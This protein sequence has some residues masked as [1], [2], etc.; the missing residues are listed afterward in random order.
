MWHLRACKNSVSLSFL[1]WIKNEMIFDRISEL[2]LVTLIRDMI[3]R[4]FRFKN[5]RLIEILQAVRCHIL[6][7]CLYHIFNL[8][9]LSWLIKCLFLR[10]ME[11]LRGSVKS[12]YSVVLHVLFVSIG[13]H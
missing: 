2:M 6:C 5:E 10:N 13:I 4:S 9:N 8:L 7:L 1:N 3:K 11:P 12:T